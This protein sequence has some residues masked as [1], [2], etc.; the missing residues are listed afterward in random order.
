MAK[1]D[2]L[3]H[4]C[5][6]IEMAGS[7]LL[8]DPFITHNTLASHINIKDIKADF[9]LVTHGHQDHV[10]DLMELAKQTDATVLSCF[11]ITSWV[12]SNGHSKIIG[13]NHG[14]IYEVNGLIIKMVN[15]VHSSSFADGTYAGNP[16][17]FVIWSDNFGIYY[18]GDTALHMDMMLIGENHTI[19]LAILPIGNRF[20]M[21]YE[22]AASAAGLAGTS[23][24]IG[25]HYDTFPSIVIDR[26]AAQDY[27]KEQ[28]KELILLPI[29]EERTFNR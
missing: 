10:A 9:I 14:G 21:G 22:D 23:K 28:G 26:N 6:V 2:Y 12:E 20:T 15:A 3:G 27:F 24:V 7:R 16:A 19:D 18:S 11:E 29:G 8:F 17:G 1:V 13:M 4:S 5:F 25:M